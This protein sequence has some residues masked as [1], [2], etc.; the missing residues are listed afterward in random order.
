MRSNFAEDLNKCQYSSPADYYLA[1][2][3]MKDIDVTNQLISV[4][5]GSPANRDDMKSSAIIISADAIVEFQWKI[6]EKPSDLNEAFDMLRSLSGNQHIGHTAVVIFG[7]K[8]S[9]SL[10]DVS[11]GGELASFVIS[12]NVKFYSLSEADI[13]AYCEL[14]QPYDKAG[15]YGIQGLGP[16]SKLSFTL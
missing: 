10:N 12:S 1:T 13:K 5:K 8:G 3:T 2:A 7:L 9:A 4:Q 6:F 14:D 11:V 15:S 16:N